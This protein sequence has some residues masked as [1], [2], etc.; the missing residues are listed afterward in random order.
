MQTL[1]DGRMTA[2]DPAGGGSDSWPRTQRC[3]QRKL[4]AKVGWAAIL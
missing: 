3:R 4:K 1:T 2:F